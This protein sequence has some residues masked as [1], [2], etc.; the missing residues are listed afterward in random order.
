MA[1]VS[2][3]GHDVDA[4]DLVLIN[5]ELLKVG[6]SSSSSNNNPIGLRSEV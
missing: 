3:F 2:F 5:W 4:L 6:L 1:V